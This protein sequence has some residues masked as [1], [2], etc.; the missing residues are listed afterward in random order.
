MAGLHTQAINERGLLTG[1]DIGF[2]NEFAERFPN[3]GFNVDAHAFAGELLRLKGKKEAAKQVF[4]DILSIHYRDRL[5]E[6]IPYKRLREMGEDPAALL[7][8]QNIRQTVNNER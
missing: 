7:R 1:E 8:S 3:E 6:F 4:S 5:I 2:L